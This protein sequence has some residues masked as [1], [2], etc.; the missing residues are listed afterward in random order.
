M[1]EYYIR[2]ERPV[3]WD[4][5]EI[6]PDYK[7]FNLVFNGYIY[8]SD[9]DHTYISQVYGEKEDVNNFVNHYSTFVSLCN[10]SDVLPILIPDKLNEFE[11]YHTT[12]IYDRYPIGRQISFIALAMLYGQT[13]PQVMN[14]LI[15]VYQWLYGMVMPYYYAKCN[16]IKSASTI[17]QLRSIAWDYS[18]FDES[19][20]HVTV[21]RIL[22]I[23]S[24]S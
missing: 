23:V 3:T 18:Q 7:R 16:E 14:E 19:D 20:P 13:K 15:K 4:G 21:E 24:S 5:E 9:V 2:E 22:N 10:D 8:H 12:F 11:T 17:N 1:N 6:V